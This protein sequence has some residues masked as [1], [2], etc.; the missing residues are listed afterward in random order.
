MVSRGR[1]S[2]S[3]P[4]TVAT[5]PDSAKRQPQTPGPDRR[6]QEAAIAAVA[7]IGGGDSAWALVVALN[8]DDPALRE[9]TVYALGSI[10]GEAA[11]VLLQQA[12]ADDH[13]FI[14]E[15]AEEAL[16]ELSD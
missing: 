7:D 13:D 10:G 2:R 15:A 1:Y 5:T 14:R 12:L 3:R 11:I 6:V 8:D 4:P 9:Q 16:E